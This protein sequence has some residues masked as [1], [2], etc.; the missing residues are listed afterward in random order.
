MN[1]RWLALGFLLAGCESGAPSNSFSTAPGSSVLVG[2]VT[3]VTFTSRGGGLH[4]NPPPGAACDP[5]QWSYTIG[6]ADQTLSSITCT[7]TGDW[8][9]AADYMPVTLLISLDAPQWQTVRAALGAVTVSSQRDCGAD[10]DTRDLTVARGEASLT[11]GDDFYGCL[12]S[13]PV[14]VTFDSLNNLWSV[15]SAIN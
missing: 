1:P 7:L 12:P 6:F 5:S 10:A 14:F 8:T 9:L 11:Y 13:Y 3:Q 4:G 15:L 2:D